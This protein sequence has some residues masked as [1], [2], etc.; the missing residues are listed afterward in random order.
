MI[1]AS[2]SVYHY[3]R[4]AATHR[5]PKQQHPAFD[6]TS[7]YVYHISA[8]RFYEQGWA[9][10]TR[11]QSPQCLHRIFDASCEHARRKITRDHAANLFKFKYDLSA[12]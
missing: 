5:R 2:P 4:R 7:C 10:S 6:S 8:T 12:N 9:D 11:P 1:A 3:G